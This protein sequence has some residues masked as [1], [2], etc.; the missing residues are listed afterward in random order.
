MLTLRCFGEVT[1]LD[2]RGRTISLRSRKHTGLLLYLVAH[3]RTVHVRDELAYLLW[4][5]HDRKARHSLSQALYDIRSNMGPLLTVD[6]HAVRLAP[7][8][9]DYELDAFERALQAKDHKAV[10]DLYRGDFAPELIDLGAEGFDRWLDSERERC[11]VIVGLALRNAQ[12]V[13]EQSGNWDQ[14]CLAALRLVRQNEFDEE[15]HCALMRGLCMKGDPASALAH[16][17]AVRDAGLVGTALRLAELAE[18]AGGEEVAP[19]LAVREP[20]ENPVE[21]RDAEFRQLVGAFRAAGPAPV[22][23]AVVGERGMGRDLVVREFARAV[24]SAGGMVQWLAADAAGGRTDL[25]AELRRHAG[26]LRLLVLPADTGN[27][28]AID[29]AMQAE[30]MSSS[31]IVGLT[32]GRAAR[33]AETARLVDFVLAFDPLDEETCATMV[34]RTD[35]IC[36]PGQ[37]ALSARLSGGNPGL[38]R[39]IA[40]AWIS[41]GHE[42][43][44]STSQPE[45]GR[46][47][48]ERSA[49]VRSLLDDQLKPLSAGE[50]RLAAVL[51]ILTPAASAHAEAV[52]ADASCSEALDG[53]KAR[54]WIR[55]GDG[56][57]RLSRPLA[58]WVV[59][60][61]LDSQE[62]ARIHLR[63]ARALEKGGLSAKSAAAC[64]LAATGNSSR[65]F[66]LGCAVASE[67]LL[68]GRSP[69]A[70]EAGTLAFDHAAAAAD[71]LR[72]GL[73][74][75]EAELQRGRFRRAT[76][77]LHQIAAIAGTGNDLGRVQLA[78]ARAVAMAGDPLVRGLQRRRLLQAREHATEEALGRA[79]AV[80]VSVL[81]ALETGS[82]GGRARALENI[83]R[84]L[85][86]IGPDDLR[87]AG[88]WCDAFRLLFSQMTRRGTRSEAR[89]LLERCRYSLT[90]LGYE[91]IRA[92]AGAE[93]WVAMRGARLR[94]ALE[95]LRTLPDP[96]DE[97]RYGSA[98]L[99]N[100][101]AAFLELGD[102]DAALDR[103]RRCRTLDEELASP[104]ADR[105]Y[106]LLNQAQCAF[107]KGD[108]ELCRRYT[109]R[110]LRRPDRDDPEPLSAQPWALN[111]LL[112]LAH[113]DERE[114]RVCQERLETC[115]DREGEDDAYLIPWFL[116]FTMGPTRREDAARRLVEAADRTAPT[117]RLSA[118]KLRVLAGT[119]SRSLAREEHRRARGVLRSAG[120]SWFVRFADAW[121]Q[122]RV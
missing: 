112:A 62:R 108:V 35:P 27:W 10:I 104:E 32:Q 109:E 12:R 114:I 15:A 96:P 105:A 41:R 30:D 49:D 113:Q 82:S 22:R 74:L 72:S 68:A 51:S 70:C 11:R 110:M 25:A 38:A 3:P 116:A 64:E 78:L 46:L 44:G 34:L 102:F 26:K 36:T 67:A 39:A 77:L 61:G 117:D 24:R 59:A 85:V 87:F 45:A 48:Y 91:G 88:T 95:L 118:Q 66:D 98:K 37:A 56:A 60:W 63:A 40:R 93:V 80:Q 100:L 31:V 97:N 122:Q 33:E 20:A 52:L 71:R 17:R 1:T 121:S 28:R 55:S 90:H 57:I 120:A 13:A 19:Y 14:A 73:V 101:G 53:L 84:A 111:G 99:N 29:A 2:S 115:A 94:D 107:F 18:W 7:N 23:V 92:I 79:M 81:T 69:V 43:D 16:Y 58:G 8:R 75:A 86:S 6:T 76:A 106:T 54:G 5:S 9:I 119:L 47:A 65:A 89:L 4:E 42:L 103:L 50:R 83:R 21:G